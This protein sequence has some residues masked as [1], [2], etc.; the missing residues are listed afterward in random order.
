M[1]TASNRVR[2][3]VR[4]VA[5]ALAVGVLLLLT[6]V[7]TAA[8]PTH[9]SPDDGATWEIGATLTFGASYA[10]LDY[11]DQTRLKVRWSS[12]SAT[13]ANGLLAT[14]T[15]LTYPSFANGVGTFSTYSFTA[16]S[17]PGTYYWQP[18]VAA[19]YWP[20]RP[21]EV[22][23]IR[24][25][26]AVSPA[27]P[28][29]FDPPSGISIRTHGGATSFTASGQSGVY[30]S[31]RVFVSRSPAVDS[32][33]KLGA[34]VFTGYMTKY[35]DGAFRY[36]TYSY[37]NFANLP[38]TYYWQV[39]VTNYLVT[40][41]SPVQT[42][43]VT[44]AVGG[45]ADGGVTRTRIPGW[46]GTRGSWSYYVNSDFGV[47]LDVSSQY[48]RDLSRVSGWRWGLSYRGTT[49]AIA[50]GFRDGTS[51]VSFS[52]LM[53]DGDLGLT[54]TWTR[55]AVRTTRAC[56]RGK[57]KRVKRRVRQVVEQDIQINGVLTWEQGPPYPLLDRFD[58][59]SVLIHEFGHM[60]SPRNAH[61]TGCRNSPMVVSAATGEYWRSERDWARRGC[62]AWAAEKGSRFGHR[63]HLL[64][65]R[66]VDLSGR[67]V[68]K[69]ELTS[70]PLAP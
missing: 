31:A 2:N 67:P 13:D 53:S 29:D 60:A 58:L 18:Y 22:G 68:S 37:Q 27:G 70:S 59:E 41:Y 33:G 46:V 17:S 69:R 55:S 21:Q 10:A 63:G 32:S 43:T 61:F 38:G 47:P 3:V 1:A 4:R 19:S 64:E 36:T 25:L 65:H 48:F 34:D 57:C 8:P 26:N 11:T 28:T 35:S 20:S 49:S 5:W 66:V 56:R 39:E 42:L 12:S 7:A 6:P 9:A 52:Y 30:S 50:G 44:P 51:A 23:G 54:T 62:G 15:D 40:A 14:G 45:N 24:T 16:P